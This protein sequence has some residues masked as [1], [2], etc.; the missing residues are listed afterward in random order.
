[1]NQY[2]VAVYLPDD[3]DPSKED[4]TAARDIGALNEE[5]K[6]ARVR[7][8]R[9]MQAAWGWGYGRGSTCRNV[10]W[11]DLSP[12]KGDAVNRKLLLQAVSERSAVAR[13]IALS[14]LAA[15][16]RRPRAKWGVPPP[17]PPN[18]LRTCL[19]KALR[20]AAQDG[21]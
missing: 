18:S 7:I 13:P 2:V 9:S 17:L 21:C 5:M 3:F 1:M 16:S 19:S 11:R 6:A 15:L 8:F 14:T 10:S 4:E 12:R 20:S